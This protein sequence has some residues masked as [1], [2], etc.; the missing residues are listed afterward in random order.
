V[1]RD[2]KVGRNVRLYSVIAVV[3]QV[4]CRVY[5]VTKKLREEDVTAAATDDRQRWSNASWIKVQVIETD[6]SL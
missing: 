2:F 1:S 6:T 5:A 3:S 4:L